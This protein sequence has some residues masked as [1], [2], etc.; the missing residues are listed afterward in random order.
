MRFLVFTSF[1]LNPSS[2][3]SS[4]STLS[5][6]PEGSFA[7]SK[8]SSQYTRFRSESVGSVGYDT[9]SHSIEEERSTISDFKFQPPSNMTTPSDGCVIVVD[10]FSTGAYVSHVLC[11]AGYSIVSVLSADL[12]HLQ[13]L[14]SKNLQYKYIDTFEFDEHE[15]DALEKLVSRITSKISM[16]ILAVL[17]GAETGVILADMISE[18]LGLRT[19]GT[20][21]SEARRDK[22][23]MGETIRSTGVRAVKQMISSDLQ[24]VKTYIE[25]WNP[26]P[27]KVIM[28]PVNSAGSG[29]KLRV[30]ELYY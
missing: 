29:N 16:P 20:N 19:N 21:L 18:R 1:Y 27:F 8:K 24:E 28:K 7:D 12:K 6:F 26:N 3:L 25:E 11:E 2:I 14:V 30:I 4:S 13:A 22:Y 5:L 9:A 23:I 15:D 10:A 17:A